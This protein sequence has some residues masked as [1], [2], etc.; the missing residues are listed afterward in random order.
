MTATLVPLETHRSE[1]RASVLR[2]LAEV[3][4]DAE[5]G[6]IVGVAIAVVRPNMAINVAISECDNAGAML[7]SVALL[8]SRVLANLAYE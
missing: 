3:I 2:T 1:F 8:Q 6:N 5:A 7:G 4:A